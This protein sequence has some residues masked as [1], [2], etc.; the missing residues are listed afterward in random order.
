M[1]RALLLALLLGLAG[2]ASCEDQEHSH[3]WCLDT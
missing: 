1:L 2:C 3:P